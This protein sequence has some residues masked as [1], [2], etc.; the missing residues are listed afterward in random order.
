MNLTHALARF[1]AESKLEQVAEPVQDEAVRAL[2]DWLGCSFGGCFDPA[3]D[4][5][6]DAL[7]FAPASAQATVLGRGD[8]VALPAAAQ[9]FA[10]ASDVLDF[11]NRHEPTGVAV[12]VPV[13]SA[14]VPL[15]EARAAS[16]VDLVHAYTLG[17]EITCRLARALS[18]ADASDDSSPLVGRGGASR[19]SGAGSLAYDICGAV[20]AAVACGK[21][22]GLDASG[23]VDAIE[24]AATR[25][26]TV[27]ATGSVRMP[28]AA[29]AAE[30]GLAAALA[31][32]ANAIGVAGHAGGGGL[33]ALL[34]TTAAHASAAH[35]LGSEWQSCHTA[36][37]PYP[38]DAA[39]HPAIEACIGLRSR[40]RARAREVAAIELRVHP[41]A[42]APA[43]TREPRT[44]AQARRSLHHAA[45]VALVDGAAGLEQF[46]ERHLASARIAEIRAR[47]E[48]LGDD[49]L[50]PTAAHVV[51]RLGDGRVVE[52]GVRC[53]RGSAARPLTD[54]EL[55][56]KFRGLAAEVLATDQIE[57]MLALAW[58]VRALADVGALVRASIPVDEFEPA[59]LPGS[60]L[61]PR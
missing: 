58:N 13:A 59:E 26:A 36:Y 20:G 11:A 24:I 57:R 44:V 5:A 50:A 43:G 12:S 51:L 56:A 4:S 17:A 35:A 6:L 31:A 18:A 37:K 46:G 3:L 14:L 25:A 2:V 10:I 48:V 38:C 21:L 60:P 54:A 30:S 33:S 55:S 41:T 39:L 32:E 7:A 27:A 49:T 9:L 61:I 47:V 42:I 16:G 15:A 45:A 53:A 40:Q 19:D 29:L 23:L 8:R 52:H 34:D 22:L 28:A 1:V